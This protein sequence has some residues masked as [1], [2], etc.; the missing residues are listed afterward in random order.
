MDQGRS[1]RF[2]RL[3]VGQQSVG[4]GEFRNGF[5]QFRRNAQS[6]NLSDVANVAQARA[7]LF[8]GPTT[9]VFTSGSGTYTTPDDCLWIEVE[10]IGGGGAGSGSSPVGHGNGFPTTFDTLTAGGGAA[11]AVAVGGSG[12]TAT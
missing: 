12:G 10:F 2:G 4:C 3:G 9:Q 8:K 11:A 7:N 1:E 5:E 6:A